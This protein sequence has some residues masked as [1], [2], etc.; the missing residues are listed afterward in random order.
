ML[1]LTGGEGRRFGAPKHLQPHPLGGSWAGHL[2]KVFEQVFP[3]G[4]I[5]V[6]GAPIGERPELG[7]FEDPRQG[8]ARAL[9]HWAAEAQP[10]ASW[11]WVVAC[12]QI[13]WTVPGLEAWF[14]L[15]RAE[16]PEGRAWALAE[17]ENRIQYLGG[18]LGAALLPEVAA[19]GAASLRD[20]A[21]ALPC[22]IIPSLGPEWFDVDRPED[23]GER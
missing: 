11:W 1:L 14:A 21:G 19:S 5:Q 9:A 23:L 20:L 17:H 13:R 4:P 6:L 22:R 8:P 15:T 10:L 7:S 18:F 2:V 12:D 3:G 16:D